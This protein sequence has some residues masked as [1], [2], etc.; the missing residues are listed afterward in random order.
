MTIEKRIIVKIAR[1]ENELGTKMSVNSGFSLFM[2]PLFGDF[3]KMYTTHWMQF[4]GN[5][6]NIVNSYYNGKNPILKIDY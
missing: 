2:H 1:L 4:L 6:I 3:L 5:L